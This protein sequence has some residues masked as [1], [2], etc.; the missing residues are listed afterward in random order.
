MP[1]SLLCGQESTC[2]FSWLLEQQDSLTKLRIIT[3]SRSLDSLARYEDKNVTQRDEIIVPV[4]VHM[5]WH[6]PEEN[7]SDE[8]VFSQIEIL[9]R[10][11]NGE[12]ADL[13]NVPT[14][15]EDVAS[16]NG[17]RFCLAASDPQG[18][19]TTGILRIQSDIPQIGIKSELYSTALGGSDAWD[20]QR[21][22]NIWVANTGNILTG[23]GTYPGQVPPDKEGVVVHP[24]YFGTNNSQRYN[25]GRVAVHE[26][27]HYF[28]LL[29]PWGE[30]TDCSTDDGVSDT[31]T[32]LT[33]YKG[34]P[35]H[36]QMSCGSVNM[37][38]NFMDYVDDECMVMFTK[39][40]MERILN[41]AMTLRQGLGS[42]NISCVRHEEN[43]STTPFTLSPNPSDGMVQVNFDNNNLAEINTVE[44]FNSIGQ[45]MFQ[46]KTVLFDG[47][48]LDFNSLAP[49]IYFVKIGRYLEKIIIKQ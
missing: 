40:Q 1:C 43:E 12:N 48:Q 15:F 5:V 46:V 6:E 49:G 11:F 34:C 35:N 47:K 24:K 10:D 42:A 7:I 26:V 3:T 38:M 17:I 13:M 2:G 39:G 9:N 22:L 41:T 33:S 25:L 8:R 16:K 19:T 29:H 20:P 30:D 21:Y 31:P 37:F 27:G 32:Q 4:V 28:G 45:M 23:L 44:V 18:K 14:E 36:P